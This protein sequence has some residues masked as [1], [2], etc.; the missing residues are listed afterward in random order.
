MSS[1]PVT[2]DPGPATR[3]RVLHALYEAAEIEHNLMCTYLYAAFSLKSGVEEGLRPREAEATTR[4][5]REIRSV[6][7]DEMSHLSAV[8]N[9]TAAL[10]GTPRF[11]RTNFPLDP[12]YLPAS[13]VVRLA[14]FSEPVLQHF[15]FLER[16]H[17][18]SECEGEGFAPERMWSR[19]AA[20]PRLTPMGIDYSTVG[21]FYACLA[22]SLRALSARLGEAAAFCGDPALQLSAAEIDLPG[23]RRVICLKTALAA[24]DSIVLQGEGAAVGSEGSHYERFIAIRSEYQLLKAENPAFAPSHPA[25]TNPVLRRPPRPEGRVWIEAETSSAVVDLA[26]AAYGLM[27][28]LLAY[29][30][31]VAAPH[32]DKALA[33]DLGVG[34]MR[35]IAPLGEYAA[36]LPAGA[37]HPGCNAGISFTTLRDTAPLPAGPSAHRF[38]IERL[39]ELAAAATS[40]VADGNPRLESVARTLGAL[41]DKAAAWT[42]ATG[43]VGVQATR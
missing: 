37:S 19:A 26:N 16:P 36:R 27:L 24:F 13:I 17:G 1:L 29:S 4:W 42:D 6:A 25:A 21:E 40:L 32:P 10:G 28:R 15:I 31:A 41:A 18:S 11:G 30:Y 22:V 9:I 34:L 35:S 7:I 2:P 20:G 39:S 3:E 8:W 38:F 14:P 43:I 23:A 33:V 12:G 5:R